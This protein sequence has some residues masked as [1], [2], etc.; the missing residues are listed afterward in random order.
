[1]AKHNKI[2]IIKS[3]QKR[4][5][6]QAAVVNKLNKINTSIYK[7]K[8]E[9]NMNKIHVQGKITEVYPINLLFENIIKNLTGARTLE[10]KSCHSTKPR[11]H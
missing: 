9:Y 2:R 5:D 7:R 1:M 4:K 10:T 8:N 11:R 3:N 6:T